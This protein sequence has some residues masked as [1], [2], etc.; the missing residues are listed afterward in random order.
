MPGSRVTDAIRR[1]VT[2]SVSGD[3][4]TGTFAIHTDA[5]W[6][7][8]LNWCLFNNTEI[9][10]R[11]S[12]V[13]G[14]FCQL[15]VKPWG[16]YTADFQMFCDE[17]MSPWKPMRHGLLLCLWAT[18]H[19]AASRPSL[20]PP[21]HSIKISKSHLSLG[22]LSRAQ[23]TCLQGFGV[24]VQFNDP[25]RLGWGEMDWLGRWGGVVKNGRQE[26]TQTERWD[27]VSFRGGAV[28]A[29]F[30]SW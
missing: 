4:S 13:S 29:T 7:Q 30:H 20:S 15:R 6:R 8:E 3:K 17:M 27:W 12:G 23:D 14:T 19:F 2:E 21:G 26:R 5:A 22:A 28:Y 18:P 11:I 24:V 1:W 10:H 9:C 25:Q 16:K